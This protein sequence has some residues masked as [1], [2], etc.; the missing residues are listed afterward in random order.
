MPGYFYYYSKYSLGDLKI[1][2]MMER[3]AKQSKHHQGK[4]PDNKKII[5]IM[6]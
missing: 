1:I 2:L 5:L 4:G 3:K 6:Q